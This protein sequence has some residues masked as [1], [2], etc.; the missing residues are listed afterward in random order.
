MHGF[1]AVYTIAGRHEIATDV[2]AYFRTPKDIRQLRLSPGQ[3]LSFSII[4]NQRH[5]GTQHERKHGLNNQDGPQTEL[6]SS[7]AGR[8]LL[9]ELRVGRQVVGLG[10]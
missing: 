3:L 9:G 1:V 6:E 4:A 8:F 5:R 2:V 7:S 10:H